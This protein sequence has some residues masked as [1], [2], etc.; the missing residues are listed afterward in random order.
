MAFDAFVK[1]DGIPGDSTDAAHKGWIEILSY[2]NGIE[3]P[4]TR[5]ASA[6]GAR[7][8][9]RAN[10]EPFV[11]VKDLDIATPLLERYLCSGKN[12]PTIELEL[13]RATG[14]KQKYMSYKLSDSIITYV[15]AQ[16]DC[17]GEG[18]LPTESV[19]FCYGKIEWTY[20]DTDEKTG[21]TKGNVSSHW[22]TVT[23][24]GG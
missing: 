3:Q 4:I 11:I 15:R 1:I 5:S 6:G 2:K 9:E 17:T 16:G 24:T 13:C 20:T 8:G 10:H 12:I 22:D 18:A 7:A 14:N 19:G 23:N 21:S